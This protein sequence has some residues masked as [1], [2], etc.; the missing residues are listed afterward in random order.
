MSRLAVKLCQHPL[1][2]SRTLSYPRLFALRQA[3]HLPP[4][5]SQTASDFIDFVL[6]RL[7]IKRARLVALIPG[8][9]PSGARDVAA[10]ACG[11]CNWRRLAEALNKVGTI[12]KREDVSGNGKL[13]HWRCGQYL[14]LLGGGPCNFMNIALAR[15]GSASQVKNVRCRSFGI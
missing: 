1:R 13:T 11:L 5:R 3:L 8:L 10:A 14:G 4:P 7:Q 12:A 9:G 6:T 15:S 2:R